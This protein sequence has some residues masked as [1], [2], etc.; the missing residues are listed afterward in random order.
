MYFVPDHYI[1]EAILPGLG[2]L[3]ERW[4][5]LPMA[6]IANDTLPSAIQAGGGIAH[7]ITAYHT[8]P[9]EPNPEGLASLQVGVDVITFTS[10]STVR[11][12]VHLLAGTTLDPMNLPGSPK[13]V[14]IGPKTAVVARAL[15]FIVTEVAEPH[16]TD[17]IV[18]AINNL[19]L[20]S[21]LVK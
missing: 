19:N 8:I 15:G 10:G 1:A 17:G 7:V 6:D 5:L 12:F 9:A 16:T 13:I 2:E 20:E 11:N 4:F 14:C 18:A 21:S 3:N